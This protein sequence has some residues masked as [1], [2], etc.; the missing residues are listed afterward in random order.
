MS[1]RISGSL[2]KSSL[3]RGTTMTVLRKAKTSALHKPAL[4]RM[5]GSAFTN[6]HSVQTM[7]AS[8]VVNG[9]PI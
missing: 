8:Y 7:C 4:D 5:Q 3:G 2:R 9:V 6:G 1:G